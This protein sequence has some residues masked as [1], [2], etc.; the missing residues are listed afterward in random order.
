MVRWELTTKLSSIPLL[1]QCEEGVEDIEA[2]ATEDEND[3]RERE[4][5]YSY[6]SVAWMAFI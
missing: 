6:I 3:A 5:A 2:A 1:D 4:C